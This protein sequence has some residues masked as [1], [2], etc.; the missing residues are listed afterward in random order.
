MEK[1]VMLEMKDIDKVFPGVKALDKAQLTVKAG[2]VH[3][4][5]GENGA[6][7]STL[8]KCL[9]GIYYRDNG[10]VVLEG[11]EVNFTNSK[12]ALDHGVAMIHQELQPI[13]EMTIA[14]NMFL[15]NY[16]KKGL[17]VDHEKMEEETKK[18]LDIIGLNVS[19]TTKLG[20]LTISQQQSVE[21]AK[22]VSHRAKILIMD[23]PTSSLTAAEV[24]NLFKVIDALRAT[25]MGIIYISHKMDEILRISDEITIMR[26]GQYVGTFDSHQITINEIIKHMVGRELVNQF[27]IKD[28]GPGENNILEV[29]NYTSPNPLS[30]QNCSFELKE[31]EILGV[32]GLVG[33]QRSE[34]MEAVF[35][36]RESL[37]GAEIIH[38]GK[39]VKINDPKEAIKNGFALV[40]ED[41]RGSGI[42]G[43]LSV[44]DNTITASLPKYRSKIGLLDEKRI[45]EVVMNGINSMRTKTPSPETAIQNLSGGNQQKVILARWLATNPDILILDEPTRGIDVGAKYEIYEIINRLAKQGKSIIVISSEMSEILGLSDRIMVMCEGKISGFLDAKEATQEKVMDLATKFMQS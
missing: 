6:G 15:G 27:P 37:P 5:M 29:K 38:R 13:P 24:E 12:E 32:A 11:Q 21:I 39:T 3:A 25:G 23:E 18:F 36:L 41:R 10:S 35:G 42:F 31:G 20:E 33:A 9:Y 16:P 34:L 40:T 8:M 44:S 17:L 22:A 14:E 7:K 28:F 4:L 2:T 19:P 30:F 1:Q 26:D 43:V 45:A